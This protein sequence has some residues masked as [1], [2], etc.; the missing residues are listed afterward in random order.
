MPVTRWQHEDFA[1]T[2][3]RV[4]GGFRKRRS[5]PALEL[6]AGSLQTVFLCSELGQFFGGK[7]DNIEES[8]AQGELVYLYRVTEGV[9][10]PGITDNLPVGSI[11]VLA[12]KPAMHPAFVLPPGPAADFGHWYQALPSW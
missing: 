10:Y 12:S 1:A 6:V 9:A 7:I 5:L 3:C 2:P 11:V 8:S 4:G